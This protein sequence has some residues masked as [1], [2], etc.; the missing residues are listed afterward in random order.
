[1]TPITIEL[2]GEPKGKGRPRH[3]RSGVTYTP[4]G[5]R[6]YEAQ[7]AWAA[8]VA[9]RGRKPLT[10]P[11]RLSVTAFIPIPRSWSGKR[12]RMAAAGEIRPTSRPDYD[13]I[14]KTMDALNGI[15]W[16]DDA[17]IIDARCVKLYDERPRLK[18]TVTPLIEA[19]AIETEAAA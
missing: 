10:G 11:L 15:V 9:M 13:N 8:Q 2:L 12:Q 1:M 16:R 18:I 19:Q 14:L 4:L 17:Q 5:T 3:T 6:S 7:L